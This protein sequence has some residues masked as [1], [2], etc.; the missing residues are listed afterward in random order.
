MGSDS[1]SVG[2]AFLDTSLDGVFEGP[3]LSRACSERSMTSS[4]H[5]GSLG[6]SSSLFPDGIV[7]SSTFIVVD[8]KFINLFVSFLSNKKSNLVFLYISYKISFSQKLQ[9]FSRMGLGGALAVS[10][11]RL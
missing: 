4:L 7:L 8:E 10:P 2:T 5:R 6:Y 11:I 3:Q 1:D 9:H